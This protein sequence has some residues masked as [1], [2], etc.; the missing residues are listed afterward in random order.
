MS[1]AQFKSVPQVNNFLNECIQF[2]K[3]T[4][5]TIPTITL[6][7]QNTTSPMS[8]INYANAASVGSCN[9]ACASAVITNVTGIGGPVGGTTVNPFQNLTYNDITAQFF[10]CGKNPSIVIAFP[11]RFPIGSLKCTIE[12]QG[13]SAFLSIKEAQ[14]LPPILVSN[15]VEII[16]SVI[17]NVPWSVSEGSNQKQ[18]I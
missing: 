12:A 1:E 16:G 3:A 15:S 2:L 7:A 8:L 14:V 17:F 6:G 4:W 13:Y 10:S 11:M 9:T 18:T 5:P